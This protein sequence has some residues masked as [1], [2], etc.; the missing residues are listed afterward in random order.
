MLIISL[1]FILISSV[2]ELSAQD[3]KVVVQTL[4]FTDINNRRYVWKFPDENE[5]F[6]KILM[7]VTLKCDRQT[8]HDIYDCGEW[9][10]LAHLIVYKHLGIM[11]STLYKVPKY[12]WGSGF[13]DTLKFIKTPTKNTYQKSVRKA[14]INSIISEKQNELINGNDDFVLE[15]K[16]TKIQMLFTKDFLKNKELLSKTF[17]RLKFICKSNGGTIKNLTIGAKLSTKTILDKFE[18]GEFKTLFEG[19][20]EITN[21]GEVFINFLED[22]KSVSFQGFVLQICYDSIDDANN[23]V[24]SAGDFSDCIKTET[25]D[26]YLEFDGRYDYVN[27]GVIEE[28][29]GTKKF[30]VEMWL[31]LDAWRNHSFFFKIDDALQFKTAEEYQQPKRYYIQSGDSS[32]YG[33]LV[34]GNV[35][36]NSNWNHFA[37]VYDATKGQYD[38][39]IK[40]YM[41]G[42]E[43][44][45]NIRGRFPDSFPTADKILKLAS[46]SSNFD[47]DIDEFRIWNDALEGSTIANWMSSS[48]NKNHPNFDKLIVNYTMDKMENFVLK[49]ESGKSHDGIL[50]GAPAQREYALSKNVKNQ[51][52][53]TKSPNVFLIEGE[54]EKQTDE[55]VVSYDVVNSP[56]TV[57]TYELDNKFVRTKDIQYVWEPGTFYTFDKNGNKIDSVNYPY[58]DFL[59]QDTLSYYGNPF[60]KTQPYEIGRYITPYGK[61]LDLGQ[62]GFT[63]IYDV[64]DYRPLLTG[65]VDFEAGNQQELIDVKFEFIKGTPPRDVLRINQIWGPMGSYSYRNLDEDISFSAKSIKLLPEAKE[66]KV[67][68][69][70]TGHGHNSNDGNYPHCC[71][72]KDN[73]HYLFAN[74]TQIANQHI[75]RYTQCG[76]NPIFPQ[77]G[78]WPGEREGWCPGDMVYDY[79]YEITKLVNSD[80]VV[81][82]YDITPVPADNQGMGGGNYVA[83]MELFEYSDSYYNLDAEVYNIISP[84]NE[85]YYSRYITECYPPSIVL[86]NNGKIQISSLNLQYKVSGGT[87][88]HYTWRG[89]L[90]PHTLDTIMIPI[91]G[92]EFL[93]GDDKHEFTAEIQQVNGL[94]D[95]YPANNTYTTKFNLPDYYT[96]KMYIWYK[97]NNEPQYYIY[98]IRNYAGQV[99]FSKTNLTANTLYKDEIT[100]EP[101]CYTLEFLSMRETG[102]SYWAYQ[103]QGQGY[104][105]I[106]GENDQLLKSFNP[107]FGYGIYY[108]FDLG[109][110]LKVEDAGLENLIYLYPNPAEE[111]LNISMDYPLGDAKMEIYNSIGERVFSKNVFVNENFAVKLSIKNYASGTYIVRVYN[112]KIDI[113]NKFIKK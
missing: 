42:S 100:L 82:D 10:Y 89:N 60:E 69:R 20:L 16:P 33:I 27:C 104:I 48:I 61:G 94:A 102:L 68:A 2:I 43:L 87:I 9:D 112:N 63:W 98:N 32:G 111:V 18:T 34:V 101:G 44:Q 53:Q 39:R 45:G 83:N 54:Y 76:L 108:S 72:W 55:V 19:D 41:N 103:G 5:K 49:D 36:Y 14:T 46:E 7:Y 62:D 8:A 24:L 52:A 75:W 4:K 77:G 28:L 81:I 105:R 73:V 12:N 37:I 106:Y 99:V 25:K 86:R 78:T 31:K 70:L 56:M 26:N 107:D 90:L 35:D 58:T 93:L 22:F 84:N 67:R 21:S 65:D 85:P 51:M 109:K 3:D 71:E 50:I 110:T 11:D 95:D 15:N 6:R 113:K 97:T 30:T 40:F 92:Y 74:G 47:C 17:R 88:Q 64:T 13:P 96:K 91:D 57:V 80:S 29:K 1:F 38:G 59:A 23:I 66:F 79:D